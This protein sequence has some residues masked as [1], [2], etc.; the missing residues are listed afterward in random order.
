MT[1]PHNLPSLPS[2]YVYHIIHV[3]T[4]LYQPWSMSPLC[5]LSSM[6]PPCSQPWSMSPLCFQSAMIHVPTLLSISHDPCPHPAMSAMI[7]VPTL[8]QPWSM[9]PN[10]SISHDPCLHPLSAMSPLCSQ[11]WSMSPLCFQWA[12]IHIP[13]LLCQP[14]SMSPPCYVNHDPSPPCSI[15]HD[16]CLHSVSHDPCLHPSVSHDTCLHP[17]CQPW[18]VSTLSQL[19]N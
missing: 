1:Y 2:C 14:W 10:C 13:T 3:P 7:H 5:S 6:S 8:C 17:L 19:L 15:S 9:S 12:M 16:P 18:S 4:L 11:P